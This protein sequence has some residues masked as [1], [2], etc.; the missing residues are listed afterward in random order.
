VLD[1]SHLGPGYRY[2]IQCSTNLTHWQDYAWTNIYGDVE[3]WLSA[4]EIATWR[5]VTPPAPVKLFRLMAR[6][7]P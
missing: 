1:N 4:K 2:V 5:D 7:F 6:P 3:R